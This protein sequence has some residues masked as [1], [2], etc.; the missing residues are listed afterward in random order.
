MFLWKEEYCTGISII[1]EQHEELFNIANRVYDLLKN[2]AYIDKY[3]KILNLV[4]ELKDYTVL[5]FKTEEEILLN[6]KYKKFFSHKIQ[7][8][9]FIN[10]FN[11]IDLKKIDNGQDEYVKETFDFVLDWIVSHILKTD[12]EYVDVV[13]GNNS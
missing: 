12:V 8:D 2:D 5:H 6:A 3:N 1:D 4:E 10:K 7:H 13:K 11:D 9:D